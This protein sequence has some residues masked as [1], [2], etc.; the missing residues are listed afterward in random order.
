LQPIPRGPVCQSC[1]M[2]M[3][4]DKSGGG[5]EMDGTTRSLEYCSS[6]YKDGMFTEPEI[7]VD[8]IVE[9]TGKK[10]R[11]MGMAEPVIEKNLMA[12]YGLERWKD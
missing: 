5:T 3:W 2:P 1:G 7:T 12:I 4:S 11:A 8:E 6:C 10:L 9:R